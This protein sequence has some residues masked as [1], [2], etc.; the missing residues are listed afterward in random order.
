MIQAFQRLK[1]STLCLKCGHGAQHTCYAKFNPHKEAVRRHSSYQPQLQPPSTSSQVNKQSRSAPHSELSDNLHPVGFYNKIKC[2]TLPC[3]L[4]A[5]RSTVSITY[6]CHQESML[7]LRCKAMDPT[8]LEQ[9]KPLKSWGKINLLP[10]R[11][12]GY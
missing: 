2:Q 7:H 1:A 8:N 10:F 9:K 5:M 3:F 12:L 6:S 11:K 4:T